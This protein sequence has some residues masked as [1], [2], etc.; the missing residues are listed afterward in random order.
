MLK[1]I[2]ALSLVLTMAALLGL[3]CGGRVEPTAT[4]LPTPTKSA[5]ATLLPTPTQ[6]AT[7]TSLPT[8]EEATIATGTLVPLAPTLTPTTPRK[9][10]VTIDI[11]SLGEQL[12]FSDDEM[13]VS[14]GAEVLLRFRNNSTTQQHNWVLVQ[15]GAK[16]DIAAAGLA[17]GPGSDW[18]PQGDDRIVAHTEL[19]DPGTSG[20]VRF[21]VPAAGSFQFL[22][23]FPGHNQTMFGLLEV[24]P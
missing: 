19:L 11:G 9:D 20:Q 22:C 13:T 12:K 4:A 8:P 1:K 2:L 18:I 15:F 17:A 6:A 24:T 10:V 3:A 14:A 16:D 23:T 21:T 7:P 5:T